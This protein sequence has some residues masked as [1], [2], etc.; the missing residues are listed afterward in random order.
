MTHQIS[1]LGCGW[2]GLPLAQK[3]VDN[4]FKI[5]GS[6][7]NFGKLM[8]LE[9]ANIVPY[10]IS[11]S[12]ERII[13]DTAKFLENSQI[14]IIA[15]PPKLR[16]ENAE[17]FVKKIAHSIPFIE[18]STVKKVIFISS[19]SVYNDFIIDENITTVTEDSTE[20]PNT[21]V[22]RQLLQIEQL[23]MSN[24]NFETTVIR[25][26][27][28]IGSDRNPT[29]IV[30]SKSNIENPLAPINFIDLDDCINIICKIIEQDVWNN[31]FNA[32]CP[33]HPTRRDYYSQN[34]KTLGLDNLQ[35][36]ESKKS[37][38]KIV[39]S[40]KLIKTLEYQFKKMI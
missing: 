23:L 34:A 1:I 36:N 40:E 18:N 15:I 29:R 20:V 4:N 9:N 16:R 37:V 14:L 13:G 10:I 38:G 8:T 3:L 2:L 26:G 25:F 5:K 35:F 32:V 27:G 6:T 12:E 19:T 11:I 39:S 30:A 31:V 28:L 33:H 7:T 24:Q 17:N 21:E 22:G